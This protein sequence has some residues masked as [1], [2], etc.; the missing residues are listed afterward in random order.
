MKGS[1]TISDV[2]QEKL[3][4][5]RAKTL[6]ITLAQYTLAQA[7]TDPDARKIALKR[8]G[9]KRGRK[10]I[11]PSSTSEVRPLFTK[12]EL[13]TLLVM[14]RQIVTVR[15]IDPKEQ[16]AI[17]ASELMQKIEGPIPKHSLANFSSRIERSL[18]EL[19]KPI[20][21]RNRIL[22]RNRDATLDRID[23][24]AHNNNALVAM[25]AKSAG[26]PYQ[27]P[28]PKVHRVQAKRPIEA[29]KVR[30][31][32]TRQELLDLRNL[33]KPHRF[34]DKFYLRLYCRFT[35]LLSKIK[36]SRAIRAK[37]DEKREEKLAHNQAA[38]AAFLAA[39][40]G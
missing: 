8:K 33:T 12:H 2:F 23:R 27:P 9:N 40:K 30:M 28:A 35:Y 25:K 37:A 5:Y 4:K 6:G 36:T 39:R 17:D 7:I 38:V 1:K 24:Q 34:K 32:I 14:I 19:A 29:N 15:S 13:N 21:E 20:E 18:K 11:A 3:Q 16:D 26:V 22:Q 10:K 31:F